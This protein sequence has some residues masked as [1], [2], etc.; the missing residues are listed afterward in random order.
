MLKRNRKYH[1]RGQLVEGYFARK[2]PL[3]V[4]WHDMLRRC[5]DKDDPSYKNYGGRGIKV[6]DRWHDFAN[7]VTDM[8]PRPEKMTLN[9]I[10]NNGDYEPKNC[11]WA[12]RSEQSV[13]RRCFSN[14]TSGHTG[15]AR[16]ETPMVRYEARFD[17]EGSRYRIGR[18]DTVDEA[19][20]ARAY[21]LE[22][23]EYNRTAAIKIAEREILWV[24]SSTGA[25]GVTTHPD[26]GYLARATINKKRHYVGYYNTI[27]EAADARVRFIAERTRAN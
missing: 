11:N 23:W 25:R 6:C 4:T 17:F 7:F 22:L 16:V 26:G 3:Y 9:R 14:N 13:N 24:T 18:F 19:R 5:L 1:P 15:I 12:T 20:T 21:W 27:Q 2:H 10:D 8:P